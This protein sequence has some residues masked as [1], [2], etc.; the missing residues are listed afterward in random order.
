MANLIAYVSRN[1]T[2]CVD[3][4][5]EVIESF[6]R[7]RGHR[8]VGYTEAMGPDSSQAMTWT[9]ETVVMAADGLV[10]YPGEEI[11][12]STSRRILQKGK[13]FFSVTPQAP[14]KRAC[15]K[16]APVGSGRSPVLAEPPKHLPD[17]SVERPPLLMEVWSDY[18]RERKIKESTLRD[19]E[20]RVRNFQD[21]LELPCT[22]ISR[23]MVLER[24]NEI[25]SR[26]PATASY[27]MRVLRALFAFAA[28]RY[29]SRSG[30]R[31]VESNPVT[32]LKS[33]RAWSKTKRR[34]TFIKP[35]D[36]PAWWRAVEQSSP[37]LRDYLVLLVLTGFRRN[38]AA[39]LAW[40]QIDLNDGTIRLQETKNGD[41]H[42]LP[43]GQFLRQLLENR[44]RHQGMSGY[45]FPGGVPG[46]PVS[47]GW[48]SYEIITKQ[49]GV[50]FTPHDL[51]RTFATTA[52]DVGLE[53]ATIKRLLNHRTGADVTEGYIFQ[54]VEALREPMQRIEDKI[55]VRAQVVKRPAVGRASTMDDQPPVPGD[56]I[57]I[58][59]DLE[60]QC[61]FCAEMIKRAAV[62]C[63]YCH[64]EVEPL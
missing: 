48:R 3:E 35:G 44:A 42:A 56:S 9:I 11:W 23:A 59:W 31:L 63:R 30:Q 12:A 38:E 22:E 50:T 62:L 27:A 18:R 24:Y 14:P 20:K 57:M 2:I 64:S 29:W 19:Y 43:I 55:L 45:V 49:S 58:D 34:T 28:E 7:E 54:S 53:R 15:A 36:L 16:E 26:S 25:S 10:V 41:D 8:L 37:I 61:P 47:E 40:E 4:Q 60:R 6:C 39:R 13:L 1:S 5:L 51:R 32:V 52:A 17:L 21:W 46:Q 33:T